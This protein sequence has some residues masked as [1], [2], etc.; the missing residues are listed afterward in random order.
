MQGICN[1]LGKLVI[2]EFLPA[3]TQV[4]P[5]PACAFADI[6]RMLWTKRMPVCMSCMELSMCVLQAVMYPCEHDSDPG[7][8]GGQG[9]SCEGAAR[10]EVTYRWAS[11]G[12]SQRRLGCGLLQPRMWQHCQRRRTEGVPQPGQ[13]VQSVIGVTMAVHQYSSWKGGA[14]DCRACQARLRTPACRRGCIVLLPLLCLISEM[15]NIAVVYM[16]RFTAL[17]LVWFCVTV[18]W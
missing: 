18:C 5:C 11:Y 12:W 16:V 3:L 13:S 1:A 7:W 14:L 10:V 4:H 15:F 8:R 6:T 17:W 2:A 9:H